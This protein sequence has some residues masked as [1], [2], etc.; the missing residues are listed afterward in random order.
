MYVDIKKNTIEECLEYW[1]KPKD[2][3]VPENYNIRQGV[4]IKRSQFLV[5]L[6]K[7]YKVLKNDKIIEL[8]CNCGRNL[9]YLDKEGYNNLTGIDIND[10]AIK[11]S[12]IFFPDLKINLIKN[13]IEDCVLKAHDNQFDVLFSMAVIQHVSLDSNWIFKHLCRITKNYIILIEL[14]LYRNYK[15]LIEESS[16]FKLI[17]RLSCVEAGLSKYKCNIFKKG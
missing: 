7:D 6:F 10:N 3:N 16:Q 2:H 11:K 4:T 12:K 8:G 14:D 1:S 5:K 9:Y 13:S 17:E 15:K